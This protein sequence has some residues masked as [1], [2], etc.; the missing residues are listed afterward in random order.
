MPYSPGARLSLILSIIALI[1]L[2]EWSSGQ[3]EPVTGLH[4]NPIS[5]HAFTGATIVVSP[6]LRLE[7]ATIVIRNGVIE[8]VGSDISIP[9]DARVWDL[10]GKIIYPGWID[11]HSRTGMQGLNDDHD[12][13]ALAWNP[14]IRS[15]LSAGQQFDGGDDSVEAMRNQGFTAVHS[16]PHLGIFR[17]ET[18]VVSLA[19]G[20][21]SNRLIRNGVAQSVSLRRSGSLGGG[22][23]TSQTGAISLIRQ[24]LYDANWY[25]DAQRI[26]SSN[27]QGVRRPETNDA[28]EA[29]QSVIEGNQPLLFEAVNDEEVLRSLRI[30]EE[31]SIP[32]WIRGSGHEYRLPDRL[33]GLNLPLIL[34]VNFPSAPDAGSP[35]EALNIDLSTLRHWYLAPESPARVAA[36]GVEFAITADGLNQLSDFLPNLRRAVERGLAP[37]TALAALT[38]RP[39]SILGISSTHG[40]LEE[41]K[42]ASFIVSD[43]DLL[44]GSSRILDVWIDGQRYSVHSE[45]GVDPRG[46]WAVTTADGQLTATIEIGG[47]PGDFE[48]TLSVSGQTLEMQSSELLDE[49]RRFRMVFDTEPLDLSSPLRLTATIRGNTMSGWAEILT[50]GRTEW[51]ASK[52]N[53]TDPGSTDESESDE[54]SD[55]E[56]LD[57]SELE[58]MDIRPAMEYGRTSLPDQPSRLLVRN[59][60]IWTMGSEGVLEGADLL[61]HQ[62]RVEEVGFDLPVPEGIEVIDAG[63]RHVTPG[64]IDAHLHSGIDGVNETGNAIVPEVRMGDVLNIHNIWMYRQLAGGLTTAHL[65]HGSANPVGG[66]NQH[67]KL[68]WGGLSDELKLEGAPRTV[69]FALGENVK[70]VGNNRYPETRMGTE[71]IIADHF[72]AAQDYRYRW[73]EWEE[74][75]DGLPPRRDLRMDALVDILEGEILIQ[76]HSYRQDEILML[77]QLA[78]EFGTRVVAFHHGVEAYKLAPELAEMGIGAV[79]WSDWSSFKIESY[80]ATVY[81][82]RLLNEAGVLTSLHSDN[83]QIASRMNWEAA[84]MVRAGMEPVEALALVTINTAKLLGIDDRVGSLEPGKDADFVIWSGDPLSTFTVAEQTWIDGRKYFDLEQD[85]VLREEVEREREM[86]IRKLIESN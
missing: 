76:A 9:E 31:F 49:A 33:T 39:A 10:Q 27:P 28:L 63:G 2:P 86:L 70:R 15:H 59:A 19:D 42:V 12:R 52:T 26:Y 56:E 41:G 16:V 61:V 53:L 44:T 58:L 20:A 81:N 11:A 25:R 68:R 35:E 17:G 47:R 66:Q 78:E 55:D 69:K 65:M 83:S 13:G 71:Q 85:R 67:I 79:I 1:V 23:P 21:V 38:T 46:S 57:E 8:S 32:F 48:G 3:T 43:G 18:S 22:Y 30:A 80:D 4:E 51:Y 77:A 37:E 82:A 6:G 72:R 24:T 34:P 84:K 50:E 7:Q 75:G 29:L 14:Q 62:G 74:S 73:R 64:L 45:P 36:A 60:T 54:D 40:T 5:T